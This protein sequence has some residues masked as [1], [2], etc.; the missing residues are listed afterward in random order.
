[1]GMFRGLRR[2]G[3]AGIDTT[4]GVLVPAMCFQ[5]RL[6]AVSLVKNVAAKVY[7]QSHG[8]EDL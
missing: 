6:G 2:D 3:G 8:G 7:Q 4:G 1:M 5:S